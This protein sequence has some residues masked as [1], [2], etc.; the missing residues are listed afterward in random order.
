MKKL[1][2]KADLPGWGNILSGV[3]DIKKGA[4]NLVGAGV[5]KLAEAKKDL[6]GH[7]NK[8]VDAVANT[9]N[10]GA[11][12]VAGALGV[13]SKKFEDSVAGTADKTK[14]AVNCFLGKCDDGTTEE[15]KKDEG[16]VVPDLTNPKKADEGNDDLK[17]L[18][19][20]YVNSSNQTISTQ[21]SDIIDIKPNPNFIHEKSGESSTSSEEGSSSE[22]IT[23]TTTYST[24]EVVETVLNEE[25][26]YIF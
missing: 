24:T 25:V 10:K 16:K 12:K 2:A 4:Q 26:K 19:D 15:K 7:I 8:G 1:E 11:S 13:D 18:G 17:E 23:T 9:V 3:Q 6:A 5:N 14:K 21:T 20:N 22:E